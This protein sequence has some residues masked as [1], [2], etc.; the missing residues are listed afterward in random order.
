M[1][2]SR[3][4]RVVLAVL[5]MVYLPVYALVVVTAVATNGHD[6]VRQPLA[7]FAA[8]VPPAYVGLAGAYAFGVLVRPLSVGAWRLLHVVV[9]PALAFSFV[10]LGLLLPVFAG[11]WWWIRRA[12]GP[13]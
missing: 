11:L 1:A 12:D 8:V 6:L 13:A 7:W 2:S 9:A 4:P 10:G 5:S 3:T